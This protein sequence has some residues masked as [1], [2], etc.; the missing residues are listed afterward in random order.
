MR[1]SASAKSPSQGR[2]CEGL[3]QLCSVLQE[4]HLWNAL[5]HSGEAVLE[6]LGAETSSRCPLRQADL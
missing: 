4:L 3:T 2:V 5:P 6:K 1:N